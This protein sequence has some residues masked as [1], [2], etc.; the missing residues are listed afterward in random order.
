MPAPK[1]VHRYKLNL[2]S[3]DLEVE[4]PDLQSTEEFE[5]FQQLMNLI[6]KGELHRFKARESS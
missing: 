2:V 3:G 6:I 5:L 4:V 1:Q